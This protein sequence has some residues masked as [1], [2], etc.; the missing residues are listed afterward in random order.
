[1]II[2]GSLMANLKMENYMDLWDWSKKLR[3]YG[4]FN[5][6]KIVTFLLLKNKR[7]FE[8]IKNIGIILLIYPTVMNEGNCKKN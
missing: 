1:M 2:V 7:M 5:K 4:K 8:K 3:K 6:I